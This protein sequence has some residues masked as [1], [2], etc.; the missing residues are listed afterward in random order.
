MLTDIALGVVV[1]I[2]IAL[3]M[4]AKVESEARDPDAVAYLF[5]IGLGAL[6]LV[7]RRWPTGV[8]V[9]TVAALFAYYLIGY[10]AV[11]V[12]V[13]VAGAVYSAAEQGRLRRR[14]WCRQWFWCCPRCTG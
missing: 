8:L 5:A 12:A 2:A 3:A 10:P 7:R 1:A 13:P 9:A 4:T 6:M 11:G 14:S